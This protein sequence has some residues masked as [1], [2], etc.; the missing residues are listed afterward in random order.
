MRNFIAVVHCLEKGRVCNS[1]LQVCCSV[2]CSKN[3]VYLCKLF[4]RETF[5]RQQTEILCTKNVFVFIP[6]SVVSPNK[7]AKKQSTACH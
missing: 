4:K 6:N 5:C 1:K 2:C 7:S 3:R